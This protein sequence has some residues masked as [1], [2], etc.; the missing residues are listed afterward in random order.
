MEIK[1]A[2]RLRIEIEEE[3]ERYR[4]IR[5]ALRERERK[6]K[7]HKEELAMSKEEK[8]RRC[9]KMWD[10]YMKHSEAKEYF[11]PPMYTALY[12]YFDL[13]S[14]IINPTSAVQIPIRIAMEL[15]YRPEE[16]HTKYNSVLLEV[17]KRRKALL[18]NDAKYLYYVNMYNDGWAAI[19]NITKVSP[20]WERKWMKCQKD[21]N[22]DEMVYKEVFLIPNN[23]VK[24]IK[25]DDK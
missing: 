13:Y 8:E 17:E 1:E 4:L 6:D 14:A 3:R 5:K 15:K 2:T 25:L 9:R 16:A 11:A 22:T 7:L 12:E 10:E 23:E 18:Y 19:K 20:T 24:W 21:S